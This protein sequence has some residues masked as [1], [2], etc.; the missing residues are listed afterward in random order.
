M[1]KRN[2]QP[3]KLPRSAAHFFGSTEVFAMQPQHLRGFVEIA[4]RNGLKLPRAFIE[5]DAGV[6]KVAAIRPSHYS[7]YVL[8]E[9]GRER[10]Q[11]PCFLFSTH[12][13]KGQWR[14][15]NEKTMILLVV[16]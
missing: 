12:R 15:F 13:R 8:T 4:K 7:R 9:K 5:T 16:S 11:I 1:E 10:R 2:G 6:E 14:L 3:L